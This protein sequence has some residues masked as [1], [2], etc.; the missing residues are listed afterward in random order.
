MPL[1]KSDSLKFVGKN[2][3]NYG[4]QTTLDNYK[5]NYS[6]AALMGKLSFDILELEV[7]GENAFMIGKWSIQREKGD[8]G[9]H[10][11]L[12]WKKINGAWKVVADHTS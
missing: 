11:T 7:V 5:K 4:W 2:G 9:G 6:N 1:L 8:V 10:F 3:L 12:F